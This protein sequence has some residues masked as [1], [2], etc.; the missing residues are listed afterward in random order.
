M[1]SL[2]VT[3][4]ALYGTGD[5]GA[6]DLARDKSAGKAQWVRLGGPYP[7]CRAWLAAQLPDVPEPIRL[8]LTAED[9]RPRVEQV[10]EGFL[11]VFRAAN[12]NP[13][14]EPHEMVSL[15]IWLEEKRIVTVQRQRIWALADL[16]ETLHAGQGPRDCGEL[17]ARLVHKIIDRLDP[18][19]SELDDAT[20]DY[21]ERTLDEPDEALR[22]GIISVRKQAILFRR[23]IAPQR[24]ALAKLRSLAPPWIG[25]SALFLLQE[26]YDH[27]LR[28]VEDL[29][30]IR[31]RCLVMQ[32]ELSSALAER[33]NARMYMLSIIA[34]IFLPLGFLTGLLGVNLSGIPAAEHPLAFLGFA[35]LLVAVVA[36]QVVLFKRKGWF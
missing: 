3:A 2:S 14:K 21:E 34:A 32:E 17:L 11:I 16:E 8:A 23:H 10:G 7:D 24:E 31:E 19:L 5:A 6:L 26:G 15:R 20:D 27:H 13:G 28:L 30:V 33:L 9:T 22:H 36:A 12:F 4:L 18:V 35:G 29:D 1:H 25:S